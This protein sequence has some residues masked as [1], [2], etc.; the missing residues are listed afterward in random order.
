MNENHSNLKNLLAQDHHSLGLSIILHLL[1]GIV[2][3]LVFIPLAQYFWK[4]NLP[5]ILAFYISQIVILIPCEL[6]IILYA[7]KKKNEPT[8]RKRTIK[9]LPSVLMNTNKNSTKIR[10][11]LSFLALVWMVLIMGV[12][13]KQLG[14]S[15]LIFQNGFNWLPDYY[16]ITGVYNNP[17]QNSTGILVLV[18]I[19]T[20]IFG[21]VI[22]PY[23]EELYFRGFLMPRLAKNTWLSPVLNAVFFA[24]YHLW[25]PWMI[26]MRILALLPMIFLIWWKKDIKI[27]I[28]THI[29]L[30]LMGDVILVIPVFFL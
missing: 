8:Q 1:P 18:L 3:T 5:I 23:V 27:G 15:N 19:L 22:G 11:L 6:G 28:Y 14:V 25:T 12:V 26:P 10:I 30:N 4:I 9:E 21:A 2:T 24:L 7:S 13:D 29:A 20:L 16:D 17:E